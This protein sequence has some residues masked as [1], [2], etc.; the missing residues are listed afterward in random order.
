MKLLLILLVAATLYAGQSIDLATNTGTASAPQRPQNQSVRH[1]FQLHDWTLPGSSKQIYYDGGD[2]VEVLL[3]TTGLRI[4]DTVGEAPVGPCDLSLSGRSN[5]LVRVQRNVSTLSFDC[6]ISN[7]DGSNYAITQIPI[8]APLAVT[9][10][11]ITFAASGTTAKL[12]WMR[13][14]T[15]LVALR[16]QPPTTYTSESTHSWW[17]FDNSL[18]DSSGNSR[19]V[20]WTSPSYSTTPN[21]IAAAILKT[22]G[23]PTWSDWLSLRAGYS[24]QLDGTGSFSMADSSNT[25]S[26]FWQQLSGPSTATWSSRTASQPS[27][28]GLVFGPYEFQ[29]TVTD[30]NGSQATDT[31]EVGAVS[32]DSNG[33]VVQGDANVEKIFGPM[34]AWGQNPWRYQ[35]Y[36]AQRATTLRAAVYAN[37]LPP[38]WATWQTGT[39]AYKRSGTS[40]LS[41]TLNGAI[42]ATDTTIT[43]TDASLFS[44][45]TLPSVIQFGTYSSGELIR[46]CNRSGNTL[47]VCFD[48]RGWSNTTA[49][50]HGNGAT[51]YQTKM[52]GTGTSFLTTL[53]PNGPGITSDAYYSTGTVSVTAG[54]T[55]VNGSGV[56]WTSGIVSRPIRISGTHSTGTPFVFFSTA[57]SLTDSDTLVLARAFPAAADTGSG[58]S[59]VIYNGA[60]S[61]APE[62]SH[63]TIA[64]GGATPLVSS[65]I[66]VSAVC[67]TD[68]TAYTFGWPEA[69]GSTAETGMHYAVVK[70]GFPGDYGLSYYDEGLAHQALYLRSGSQFAYDTAKLLISYWTWYPGFAGGITPPRPRQASIISSFA[71][72]VLFPDSGNTNNWKILRGFAGVGEYYSSLNN[73]ESDYRE[74]AYGQAWS[75]LGAMFDPD[76]TENARWVTAVGSAYTRDNTCK[77]TGG[78]NPSWFFRESPYVSGLSVTGGTTA[79]TGTGIPSTICAGAIV[80]TVTLTNGSTTATLASGGPWQSGKVLIIWGA[81]PDG[82]PWYHTAYTWTSGSSITLATPFEGTNGTY[83]FQME[84][85]DSDGFNYLATHDSAYSFSAD[86][87]LGRVAACVWNS[88]TSITL[89]RNWPGS[90][91]TG[92]LTMA[93]SNVMGKGQQPFISGIKTLQMGF[94]AETNSS[95]A[96][97]RDATAGY[98]FGTGYNSLTKG[99]YY[100]S[101]TAQ[102][103]PQWDALLGCGYNSTTDFG[104]TESRILAGEAQNAARVYYEANTNNTVKTQLDEA[105]GAIWGDVDYN[106][107]GVYYDS[108]N[109]IQAGGYDFGSYKWTGFMF[110]MGMSHQWPAARVGGVTPEDLRTYSY[111]FTL[112]AGADKIQL[113]VLRP[114]GETVSPTACTTSPCSF[115]YDARQGRHIVWH[116]YKTTAGASR[117][118]SDRREIQ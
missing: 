36:Q 92:T 64:T 31:L 91:V 98:I 33:V 54:S 30:A 68:T 102:C 110:G 6:E 34:I 84:T 80:G 55:T 2:G 28:T 42:N 74:T 26:Y 89:D 66:M 72:K 50:A 12:A 69:L 56:T 24:N 113:T 58:L 11:G 19:T 67:E 41:T 22:L 21:Q 82:S 3:T 83:S 111:G 45:T 8:N 71:D 94:G 77:G 52:T 13:K 10:S 47:T 65:T 93:K 60:W 112:P 106:T 118:V 103:T 117:G 104:K 100:A 109:A 73:C 114:N 25:V 16:S 9:L 48:G 88:S 95:F 20:T 49:E 90:T 14:L 107:G 57:S 4:T 37:Y 97:L 99:L 70:E 59:Y 101:G 1:E 115:T 32:Y 15:T 38:Y 44:W 27:I 116:E 5:V 108:V 35:D 62:W 81:R 43:L 78:E 63:P 7:Y 46:I 51:V 18:A 61:V 40:G 87:Y 23:A 79:V 86:P 39:V 96:T 75:A 17:K 29:V 53:C 76:P 85:P 105:Y